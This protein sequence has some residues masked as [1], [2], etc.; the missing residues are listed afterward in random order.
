MVMYRSG[1]NPFTPVQCRLPALQCARVHWTGKLT[2]KQ[3]GHKSCGLFSVGVLQQ[4]MLSQNFRQRPA[5][6]HAN[7]LLGQL[8]QDTLALIRIMDQFIQF[9]KDWW[10][11]SKLRVLMLNLVWT[12][13]VCKWSLLFHCILSE[14]WVKSMRHCQIQRNFKGNEYLCKLAKNI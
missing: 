3:S 7:G 1:P 12:N 6:L 8:S 14:K 4:M 13:H 9:P 5:E 10:W 2:A 11:L